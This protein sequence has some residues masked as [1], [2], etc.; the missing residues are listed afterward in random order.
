MHYRGEL[1]ANRAANA[2]GGR[3]RVKQG[4]VLLLDVAQL[5][6]QRVERRIGDLRVV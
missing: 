6:H 4:R 1:V 3:R 5:A 2:L